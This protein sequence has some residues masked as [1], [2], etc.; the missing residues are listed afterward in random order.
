MTDVAALDAGKNQ[1]TFERLI[2]SAINSNVRD[3]D[4]FELS[5]CDLLFA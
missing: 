3:V 5:I 2:K 1:L 4:D